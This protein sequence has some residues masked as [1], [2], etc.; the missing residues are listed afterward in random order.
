MNPTA[1]QLVIPCDPP[2]QTHQ[3][4]LR[5][6][7][8]GKFCRIV[9]AKPDAATEALGQSITAQLLTLR[10]GQ[11]FL[12][13][14]PHAVHCSITWAFPFPSAVKAADRKHPQW[15]TQRPDL[16]NLSKTILDALTDAGAWEDDAQVSLLTLAKFNSPSPSVSIT[17]NPHPIH[18]Q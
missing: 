2:R 11:R 14:Q 15:R 5:A 4:R 3:S 10:K 6:Y 9:K 13:P 8:I 17:I 12:F 18:I 1:H 7:R 16:D